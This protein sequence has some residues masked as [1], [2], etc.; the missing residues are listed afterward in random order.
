VSCT[1][2]LDVENR[3]TEPSYYSICEVYID[4]CFERVTKD[5][6]FS[7]VGGTRKLRDGATNARV[8]QRRF[9]LPNDF[10]FIK[11]QIQR[12]ATFHLGFNRVSASSLRFGI[13]T[14]VLA[15]GCEH[16]AFNTLLYQND[17]GNNRMQIGNMRTAD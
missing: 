5:D 11:E 7:S 12:I 13:G 1:L 6:R 3:S 9:M 4:E 16:E 2:T 10:P 17:Y 14:K 8:F 15:P